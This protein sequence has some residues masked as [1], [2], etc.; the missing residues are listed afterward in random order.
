MANKQPIDWYAAYSRLEKV[1]K[2]HQKKKKRE[3]DRERYETRRP[4]TAQ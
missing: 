2:A 1:K 3:Y 4:L